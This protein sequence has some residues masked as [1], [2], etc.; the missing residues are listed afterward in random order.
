LNRLKIGTQIILAT[1]FIVLITI[2]STTYTSM[3]SMKAYIN[4]SAREDTE[5]GLYIL[6]NAVH[7]EFLKVQAFRDHIGNNAVVAMRMANGEREELQHDLATL[8]K[9]AGLDVVVA[10]LPD[11]TVLA[12][13]GRAHV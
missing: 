5:Q 8:M 1:F 6:E 11:G 4:K 2:F 9:T 12:K 10:A 3:S 13:I 7:E